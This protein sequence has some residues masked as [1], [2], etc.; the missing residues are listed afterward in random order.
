MKDLKIES[1]I[2]ELL[3]S[4]KKQGSITE[5]EIGSALIDFDITRLSYWI[6]LYLVIWF[7]VLLYIDIKSKNR[8]KDV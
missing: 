6:L 7:S 4:A 3:K 2:D 5:E 1:K 8:N